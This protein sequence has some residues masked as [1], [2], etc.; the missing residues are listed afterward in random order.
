MKKSRLIVLSASLWFAGPAFSQNMDMIDPQLYLENSAPILVH[1]LEADE[2][3]E[4]LLIPRMTLPPESTLSIEISSFIRQIDLKTNSPEQVNFK[5][6]DREDL[7]QAKIARSRDGFVCGLSILDI[8][9]E[10]LRT[11]EDL[12]SKTYCLSN[13]QWDRMRS[14]EGNSEAVKSAL[15]EFLSQ[16]QVRSLHDVS[17]QIDRE[18]QARQNDIIDIASKKVGSPIRGCGK[19]CLVVTSKFGMRNHPVLKKRR[20]HKGLDLRARTGTPVVAALPGTV[21]ANRTERKGKRLTGYGHYVIVSHPAHG[22]Q[23]LYAHL[24]K[25]QSKPGRSVKQG[26]LI[27][28]SGA[29]GIGTGAHLHFE[30]HVKARKGFAPQNP[31]NFMRGLVDRGFEVLKGLGLFWA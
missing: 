22:M 11:E 8:P 29:T 4:A 21:L 17:L 6:A 14:V 7:S 1:S 27:A 12:E 25:F 9:D 15:S 10:E 16:G 5:Y 26:D 13:L 31:I 28:S 24:S 19:G 30:T 2:K 18:I 23:T 20:Q 3:G